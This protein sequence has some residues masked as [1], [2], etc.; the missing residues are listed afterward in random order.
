M[1]KCI[2]ENGEHFHCDHTAGRRSVLVRLGQ[3]AFL[4]FGTQALTVIDH[5]STD[6]TTRQVL[7]VLQRDKV[8]IIPF[9][10]SFLQKSQV[11]THVLRQKKTELVMPLDVDEYL[12]SC[13]E[14]LPLPTLH[15]QMIFK[16]LQTCMEDTYSEKIRLSKRVSSCN[17]NWPMMFPWDE[18]GTIVNVR[19][20]MFYKRKTFINTDQGNHFGRTIHDQR[21][22]GLHNLCT[23]HRH[24][25]PD[26][27]WFKSLRNVLTY[28]L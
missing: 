24:K 17:T 28:G 25:T 1:P 10:G 14:R 2:Y 7:D 27:T 4:L 5:N 20:K 21:N 6:P 3:M 26:E 9:T 19:N 22:Y 12:V 8:D 23:H 15:R 18:N 13:D 16:S 11:V